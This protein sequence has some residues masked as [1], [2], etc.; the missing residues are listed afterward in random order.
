MDGDIIVTLS[1]TRSSWITRACCLALFL[2]LAW[3]VPLRRMFPIN[4]VIG[5]H[6]PLK[7]VYQRMLAAGDLPLWT[8]VLFAGFDLHG[9]GQLGAFHPLHLLLYRALPLDLAFNFEVLFAYAAGVA[10][11][12]WLLRRFAIHA[13][14]ALVGATTYGLGGFMVTHYPHVNMIAVVAHIPWLLICFDE[15][16]AGEARGRR[17]LAYVASALLIGSQ[18]LLGFPQAIWWTLLAGSAF[19]AWRAHATR[20][21]PRVVLPACAVLTGALIGAVQVLP[22]LSAAARSTRAEESSSFLLG[23]SLEPWNIVQLWSP[24]TLRFRAISRLDRLQFHE[25]ALYP[26][27]LL[28]LAPI[29]LWIRRREFT[30]HR[31]LAVAAGVFAAVAFVLALGRYGGLAKLLIYL[32]V[33]GSFRAPARFILLLQMGLA[34]MTAVGYEDLLAVRASGGVRLSRGAIAAISSLAVLNILTILLLNGGIIRVAPDVQLA[35]LSHALPGTV[36][37]VG[38][39]AL[40]LLAARGRRWALPALL[41]LTTMDLAAWGLYYVH[42]TRPLPVEGFVMPMPGNTTG[43]P[44]RLAGPPNWGDLALMN[45]YELVGGYA[46]LYPRTTLSWDTEAFARLAG[47]KR[48]FDKRLQ[49]VDLTGGV[50]RARMLTDVRVTEDVA[51]EIERIDL[52]RTALATTA[53]P[54]LS[55]TPGNARIVVDRPGHVRVAVDAPGRQ[56]LSLSERYDPGWSATVDGVGAAITP[57]NGD[58]LGVVVDGGSHEVD[59]RF[60]PSSFVNGAIVSAAGLLVLL[61]TAAVMRR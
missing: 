61:G 15:L 42:R 51:T 45:G 9:E 8:P 26:T 2:G 30:R 14:A 31:S 1:T 37:V 52:Q 48:R 49:V 27:T 50:A 41:V 44:M 6:V 54:P 12:Y 47:A 57:L 28:L 43:E 20:R 33:V 38:A 22:T 17:T 11:M 21:W 3:P 16:I 34:T 4:D 5:Y 56:M 39:T 59:L 58:F 32:P 46:G 55:G 29:W 25:F 13:D 10:G 18:A 7:Q 23:Y 60:L 36:F 40:L 35:K 53:I 19:V 24:Y